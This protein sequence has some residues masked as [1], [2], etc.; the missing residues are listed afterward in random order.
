MTKFSNVLLYQ[1]KALTI[2]VHAGFEKQIIWW[3]L[4]IWGQ[5]AKFCSKDSILRWQSK[6]FPSFLAQRWFSAFCPQILELLPSKTQ[7]WHRKVWM[8]SSLMT[9]A[10]MI[11]NRGKCGNNSNNFVMQKISF[12]NMYPTS[13]TMCYTQ[14]NARKRL[15]LLDV[16]SPN[17]DDSFLSSCDEYWNLINIWFKHV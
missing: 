13:R 1:N 7:L 16:R 6:H 3:H 17:G 2:M 9:E 8:S 12:C 4:T 11:W 14:L 15:L 10:P 5:N